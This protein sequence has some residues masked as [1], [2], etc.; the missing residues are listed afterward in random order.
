MVNLRNKN[1]YALFLTLL[2]IVIFGILSVS[3]ISILQSGN[4]RAYTREHHTQASELSEKG[5]QHIV[6][7]INSELKTAL[8]IEG[9]S[10][11]EFTEQ[12]EVIL[13]KYKCDLDGNLVSSNLET[14]S[15]NVC[16]SEYSN[17]TNDTGEINELRKRVTFKSLGNSSNQ[18]KDTEYVVDIGADTVPDA[19][20][21]ALSTVGPD[22]HQ[23]RPSDGNIYL[24]GGIEIYG[25]IKAG[26]HLF[27]HDHGPGLSSGS[28]ASYANW[29]ETTL[30]SLFSSSGKGNAKIVLRGNLF[31]F[32]NS[33]YNLSTIRNN[34]N[35]TRQT[36]QSYY[37]NHLD[38]SNRNTNYK[39]STIN[40]MFS[41]K[42]NPPKIVKRD[43]SG[44]NVS[45]EE[46]INE[47]KNK[48]NHTKTNKGTSI[49]N[50]QS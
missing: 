37:N 17:V 20:K 50:F 29:R 40:N 35:I 9:L 12:L 26:N 34:R 39:R 23:T 18:T 43:W 3:L 33:F 13:N 25:D 48:I 19:L 31:R 6:N 27:T 16:I 45:I 1:G 24:H 47:A 41:N 42:E 30:P 10:R 38:W 14:G 49:I 8:G 28:L 36:Y 4:K 22:G 46:N 2:V 44:N 11:S 5:L 32:D 21:Y 15:Y 7:K